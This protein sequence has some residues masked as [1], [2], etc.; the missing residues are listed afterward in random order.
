MQIRLRPWCDWWFVYHAAAGIGN[1][2]GILIHA[3]LEEG[4]AH[5][6]QKHSVWQGL[7]SGAQIALAGEHALPFG[8]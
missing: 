4:L 8:M 2:H 6:L 5:A 3:V 7:G 1:G